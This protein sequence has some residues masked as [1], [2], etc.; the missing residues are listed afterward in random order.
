[1]SVR[2]ILSSLLLLLSLTPS[3]IHAQETTREPSNTTWQIPFEAAGL[4]NTLRLNGQL[5]QRDLF[6]PVPNGVRALE[7]CAAMLF[8]AD[9]ESGYLEVRNGDRVL[10]TTNLPTSDGTLVVPLDLAQVQNGILPLTLVSKLRGEDEI[11]APVLVG[12][13]L[14]L[15]EGTLIYSGANEAETVA[16]F[17]PPLL[18][19]LQLALPDAPSAAEASSAL[20][21]AAMVTARYQV[22][23][24]KPKITLVTAGADGLPEAV[25]DNPF[26]R[27]IVIREGEETLALEQA[28]AVPVLVVSGGSDALTRQIDLL[29]TSDALAIAPAVTVQTAPTPAA[30]SSDSFSFET[31]G[32]NDLQISGVGR[33]ELPFTVSQADVGGPISGMSFRMAGTHTPVRDTDRGTLSL[34][35]NQTLI[36]AAVLD[37]DGNFEQTISVPGNVLRRDNT[38]T[39]RF[40]YVPAEGN[41]ALGVQPFTGQISGTSAV[42]ITRGESLSGFDRLPQAFVGAFQVA[43][44]TPNQAALA[45]AVNIVSAMQRTTKTVLRPIVVAWED[46]IA[47]GSPALLISGAAADVSALNPPLTTA[48]IRVVSD[49]G[50]ELLRLEADAAVATGQAFRQNDRDVLLFLGDAERLSAMTSVLLSDPLGWYGLIGDTWLQAGDNLP[51]SLKLRD[52]LLLVEPLTPETVSLWTQIQPFVFIGLLVI[53]L[54]LMVAAYPRVVRRTP[55]GA[56]S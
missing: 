4:G 14:D 25:S 47:S 18:T 23:G 42:T 29:A 27:T 28:G 45:S 12:S 17:M 53:V 1:M 15:S 34:L 3:L 55:T 32:F 35:V 38:L 46:A 13:W 49:D 10:A 41:C 26:E 31:L 21:L 19:Q 43:F 50:T 7:L 36:G 9:V 54:V 40:D 44:E 56:K 16:G 37:A 48:P 11:C 52:T 5:A 24:Q 2:R 20:Q 8:S 22:L 39:V 33:M 6:I 30:A 51:V